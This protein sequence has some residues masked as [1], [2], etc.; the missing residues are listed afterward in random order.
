MFN[1]DWVLE[2]AKAE[3]CDVATLDSGYT[4]TDAHRLYMNKGF[5]TKA[6]HFCL[7]LK[8]K[9]ESYGNLQEILPKIVKCQS[10]K[11]P[12]PIP[13][14]HETSVHEF[15]HLKLITQSCRLSLTCHG[16]IN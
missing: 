3:K 8:W 5:Y 13:M 16:R 9:S 4:R 1:L 12:N 11:Y 14:H 2:L 10:E 15:V 6:H 7:D